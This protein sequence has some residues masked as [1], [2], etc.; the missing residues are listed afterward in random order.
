MNIGAYAN[1]PYRYK[2]MAIDQPVI[3]EIQV[4]IINFW[5]KYIF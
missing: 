2:G 4:V 3:I 5:F 1:L